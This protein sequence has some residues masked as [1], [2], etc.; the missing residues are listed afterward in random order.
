MM[1]YFLVEVA[2]LGLVQGRELDWQAS[3][4]SASHLLWQVYDILST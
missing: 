3:V 1:S 2:G 4:D